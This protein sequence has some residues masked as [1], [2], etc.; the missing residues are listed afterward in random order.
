VRAGVYMEQLTTVSFGSRR[1]VAQ[2]Q[3]ESAWAQNRRVEFVWGN[4]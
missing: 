1:L 2:G 4:P 3:K